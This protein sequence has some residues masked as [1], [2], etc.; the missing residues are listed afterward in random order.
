[1]PLK[2]TKKK[3]KSINM[4]GKSMGTHGWGARKKHKKSGHHGGSGMAGTGKRADQKK[5]L[6][7]KL[8]GHGYFGKQ[9]I[10]SKKV[11]KEKEK[12]I[13]LSEIETNIEKYGKKTP[14]TPAGTWN[15]EL[16]SYKILA[17]EVGLKNYK[18]KNKLVITARSASKSAIEK[19]KKAGG[20]IKVARTPKKE[21]G[22][23][24]KS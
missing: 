4:R 23:K 12:R 10:T 11:H 19:V 2:K 13:N 5:T 3:K 1:M 14:R 21:K 18:V 15:V 24:G 22:I 8:Y 17:G 16:K 20:E 7:T 9:G 6:I